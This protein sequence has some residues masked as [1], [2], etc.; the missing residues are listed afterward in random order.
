[1]LKIKKKNPIRT[2]LKLRY[3]NFEL[4][5]SE[6][7]IEIENI[8]QKTMKI[9]YSQMSYEYGLIAFMIGK[10]KSVD[11]KLERKTEE[12]IEIGLQ[13]VG[14]L[15]NMLAYTNLIFSNVEFRDK[16]FK[17]VTDIVTKQMPVEPVD[18]AADKEI[19]EEMKTVEAMK[20]AAE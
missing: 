10:N 17:L 8:A 6:A 19:I 3:G 11:G 12:E 4:R 13:N 9:V 1:M 14:F 5:Y 20:E 16:Y 7:K 2:E 15:I 18:E